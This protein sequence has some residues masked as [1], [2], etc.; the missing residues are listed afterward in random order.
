M[1][2]SLEARNDFL[3]YLK[4]TTKTPDDEAFLEKIRVTLAAAHATKTT[5]VL[6]ALIQSE[7]S[8]QVLRDRV[9]AEVLALRRNG[10]QEAQSLH[11]VLMKRVQDAIAKRSV[12]NK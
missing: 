7:S 9:Q 2:L 3:D 12:P 5:A 4:E 1:V 10:V 6:C 8:L 11:P